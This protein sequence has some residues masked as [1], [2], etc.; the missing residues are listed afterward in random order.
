MVGAVPRGA[1]Q[2][3]GYPFLF[4]LVFCDYVSVVRLVF[5]CPVPDSPVM[6]VA[7]GELQLPFVLLR[8][9]IQYVHFYGCGIQCREF[10]I[11]AAQCFQ[12]GVFRH[13]QYRELIAGTVQMYQLSVL[14]Y[15]QLCKLIVEA[16]QFLQF[17]EYLDA[18]Q[19]CNPFSGASDLRDLRGFF[20]RDFSVLVSVELLQHIRPEVFVGELFIG[21]SITVGFDRRARGGTSVAPGRDVACL[22]R[23]G[24]VLAD[25]E[26]KQ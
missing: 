17:G 11:G 22:K 25:G 7:E 23:H 3:G 19:V 12:L 18:F 9:A 26:G 10:I 8:A 24:I 6:G 20:G 5:S 4:I 21:R 16:V 13:I 1:L 2:G 15:V 14:R